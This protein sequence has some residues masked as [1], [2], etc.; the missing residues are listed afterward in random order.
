[1]SLTVQKLEPD[2]RYEAGG[3]RQDYGEIYN[4]DGQL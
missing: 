3:E 2:A 4:W 1:M